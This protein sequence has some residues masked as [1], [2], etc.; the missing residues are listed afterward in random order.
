MPENKKETNIDSFKKALNDYKTGKLGELSTD[1]SREKTRASVLIATIKSKRDALIAKQDE[2]RLKR[3]EAEKVEKAAVIEVKQE[4]EEQNV[5]PVQTPV[6]QEA[7]AQKAQPAQQVV[8]PSEQKSE[9]KQQQP[10]P[11]AGVEVKKE[12]VQQPKQQQAP[13]IE[14]KT[15]FEQVIVSPN[16]DVRRVYVPP[17]PTQKPKVQTR[18][19]G[20]NGYQ[21]PRGNQR[22]QNGAQG[23]R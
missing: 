13:K 17:T 10:A 21:Q 15:P 7:P 3:E 22:P 16:G 12:V 9:A 11:K 4:K 19:F 18:V 14:A 5:E 1:I 6:K 8:Q 2:E 23:G 20:Q